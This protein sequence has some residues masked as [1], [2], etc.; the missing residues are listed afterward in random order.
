MSNFKTSAQLQIE[1]IIEYIDEFYPLHE[2]FVSKSSKS[3]YYR[4]GRLGIRIS[5]HPPREQHFQNAKNWIYIIPN[6]WQPDTWIVKMPPCKKYKIFAYGDVIDL[7]RGLFILEHLQG[8]LHEAISETMRGNL[9][10]IM[11]L[12][13]TKEDFTGKELTSIMNKVCERRCRKSVK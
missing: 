9:S 4:F 1:Q 11:D 12:P 2:E 5:D 10:A 13:I 6:K 3:R 7:I 8:T